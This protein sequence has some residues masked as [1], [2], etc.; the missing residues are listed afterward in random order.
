MEG[1][2]TTTVEPEVCPPGTMP[3]MGCAVPIPRFAPAP[4]CVMV[5][6]ELLWLGVGVIVGGGL[7]WCIVNSCQNRR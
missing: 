2:T 6:K 1:D 5:R 7:I 3:T 4:G